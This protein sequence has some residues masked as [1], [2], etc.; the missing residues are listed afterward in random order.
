MFYSIV[1]PLYNKEKFIQ[2]TLKSV[3]NQTFI[4]FEIIVVN[5]GSTDNS[6]EVIS[7]INDK[8][9]HYFCKINEGVSSA[10]NFG[11]EKAKGDYIC[12]LDADDYWEPDFLFEFHSVIHK[13]GNHNVFSC[14]IKI[15]IENKTYSG[16]Y[17]LPNKTEIQILNYFE[18]SKYQSIISSSSV[19][20]KRCVFEKIGLF[21]TKIKMDEDTDFW[22]RVGIEYPIIFINKELA[23]YK[24]TD[25]RSLSKLKKT[26]RQS[27]NYSKFIEMEKK[28]L[29]LKH[30][31]DLNRFSDA[32]KA[33]IYN[34]SESFNSF[35]KAINKKNLSFKKRVLL[36][37]PKIFLSILIKSQQIAAQLGLTS[38]VFK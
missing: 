22:I 23:I 30:F 12:L 14:A 4:D 35:Y 32:I 31:L 33:K 3:L 20:F 8:R 13:N 5:D 19:I 11:I 7:Q 36:K 18:A 6:E 16:K 34:D 9:V 38:S 27:L 37:L 29:P 24:N 17:S 21:D 28:N 25:T 10:R 2:T 15:E 26:F 1:I